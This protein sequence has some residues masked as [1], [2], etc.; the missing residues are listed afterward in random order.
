[1]KK[2]LFSILALNNI[3]ASGTMT[4]SAIIKPA[5]IV[6]FEKTAVMGASLTTNTHIFQDATVHVDIALAEKFTAIKEIYIN[7][8]TNTNIEMAIAGSDGYGDLKNGRNT[9]TENYGK[10]HSSLLNPSKISNFSPFII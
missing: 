3:L 5:S 1:M 2:T 9:I 4:V 10:I 6:G 8:N 7:T